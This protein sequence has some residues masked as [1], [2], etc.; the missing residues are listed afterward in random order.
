MLENLTEKITKALRNIRGL[1]KL[2]EDN[3]SQALGDVRQALLGADVHFKVVRE[4]IERVK[5]QSLGAE[6]LQSVTPAQQFVKIIN[7]ELV[8][9]L[10]EGQTELSEIRPLKILMVGLHGSGKTTSSAKLANLLK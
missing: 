10:G 6:V 2:S 5:T 9:L 3:I 1:G 8:K 7:D 4:F